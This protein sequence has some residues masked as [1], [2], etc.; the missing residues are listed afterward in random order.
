MS[1]APNRATRLGPALAGALA[2]LGAAVIAGA[3]H[4][5]VVPVTLRPDWSKNSAA[6]GPGRQ[7]SG[8]QI[9]PDAQAGIP[10]QVAAPPSAP[11]DDGQYIDLATARRLFVDE[12]ALFLDA[13][14]K[15]EYDK[16]HIAGAVHLSAEMVSSGRAA[17]VVADL[18]ASYGYD[19]P[20]VIYCH[21]GDCDASDNV[22][23]LLLPMGFHNLRVM[24]AGFADWQNAGYEVE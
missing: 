9:R 1:L 18:V 3:A 12:G 14:S 11:G 21:G 2:L 19:F 15:E 7:E 5:W 13:R 8:S 22:A 16:A 4:S 20:I 24:T 6:R 17:G 10:D 23:K